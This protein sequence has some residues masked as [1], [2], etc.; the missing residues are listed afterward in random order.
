ME[1]NEIERRNDM[2]RS[3]IGRRENRQMSNYQGAGSA[4]GLA[5]KI[6]GGT[7]LALVAAA[8]LFSLPDIKRYI[9]ISTM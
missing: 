2:R 8:V 3:E 7:A 6:V 5:W 9:K 1:H 4:A